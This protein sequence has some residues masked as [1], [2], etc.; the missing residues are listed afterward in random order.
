[1]SSE[2][3]AI[4]MRAQIALGLAQQTAVVLRDLYTPQVAPHMAIILIYRK[5]KK[6]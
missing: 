3:E 5:L 6:R 4:G 1:M 2:V